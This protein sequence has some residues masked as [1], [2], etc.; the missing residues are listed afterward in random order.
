MASDQQPISHRG[1]IEKPLAL[2]FL[3]L[4]VINGRHD[5]IPPGAIAVVIAASGSNLLTVKTV[6]A[7]V[8]L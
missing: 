2:S 8:S 3:G 4:A 1:G 5:P 6:E 7:G